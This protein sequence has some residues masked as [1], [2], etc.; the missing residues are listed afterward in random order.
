MAEP[1]SVPAFSRLRCDEPM[2]WVDS[3][4]DDD[5]LYNLRSSAPVTG[6]RWDHKT[7]AR[8]CFSQPEAMAMQKVLEEEHFKNIC[9]V[10][11]SLYL[12]L[13]RVLLLW[14]VADMLAYLSPI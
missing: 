3:T 2:M 11:L 6:H 1:D 8:L 13:A 4:G 7:P 12:G 9:L 10:V 5:L 14:Q